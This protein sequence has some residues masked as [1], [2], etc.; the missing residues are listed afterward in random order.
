M[1]H[2]KTFL[3]LVAVVC[4]A[5]F[6]P[7]RPAHA[8]MTNAGHVQLELVPQSG[9]ITPGQSLYVALHEKIAPGWH[10]YWRNPGDAGEPPKLG[11]TLPAGWKAGDIVWPQPKRLPVGPLMDYGYEDEVYLPIPITAPANALVGA[12][13]RLKTAVS[14]LVCKD[15]CVPEDA[16]VTVDLPVAQTPGGGSNAAVAG[17]LASAPR[18][19]ALDAVMAVNAGQLKLAVTGAEL[20]GPAAADVYFYPYDSTVIDHAK[21][22]VIERGPRGLT[23]SLAPGYAFKNGPRPA[24]ISGLLAVDGRAFEITA[25]PGALPATAAGLGAPPRRAEGFGGFEGLPGLVL[26]AGFAFLGGAVLNLMPCVFPILSMKALALVG[27]ADEASRPRLQGVAFLIGV[28]ATFVGLAALLIAAKAAG[29]AVGWGFQLQSPGVVAAL[30]LA[31]LLIGLNLSGVFEAGLSLQGAAGGSGQGGLLGSVLTGALAVVVAAPCTAPFMASAIAWALTQNEAA[32]LTVFAALG[33][34]F[35]APFT[36]LS[37]APGLL[38]KL[39]RP[40]PWMEVLKKVLAFPMYGAAAWL[41]WVATLQAGTTA[42]AAL[43]A[44]GVGLALAAWLYGAAQRAQGRGSKPLLIYG[45]SALAAVLAVGLVVAGL[46]EPA[47]AAATPGAATS[48]ATIPEEPFS[49][50]RLDQLRAQG[51]PVFVD[52]TAAWCIT[53]Q[54]NQRAALSSPAVAQAFA[55]AGAVYLKADWTRRDPEIAKALAD[56]GRAGVPLYLVYGSGGGEPQVLPQ[57][58]SESLVVSALQKAAK[59]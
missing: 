23:L 59:G 29:A 27:H 3:F 14:I 13:A 34:G 47:A 5:S 11:W 19:A 44:G 36:L 30:A 7:H 35:A 37:F 28:L 1:T 49:P 45:V 21:P 48:V 31:M 41:V 32:A 8:A 50:A 40:G 12:P 9:Q 2:L 10:T 55:R 46:R 16:T 53:C 51:K 22:Q 57:L 54:V 18:R 56:Q 20:H 6:V 52:F 42:L 15:T 38:R 4:V 25:K 24:S 17:A 33:L 39:P 58:L 26:A 43:L